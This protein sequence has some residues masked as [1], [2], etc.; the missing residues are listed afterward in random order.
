MTEE[1]KLQKELDELKA[2]LAREK[3]EKAK[4]EKNQSNQNAYITKLE[5]KANGL[6]AQIET[7]KTTANKPALDPQITAYFKKKYVEDFVKEGK[8][9]LKR[10]DT[11]GVFSIM[12]PELDS[13][14]KT[15]MNENN[16]SLKFILDSYSLL[17][18]RA[19]A[20]PEHAINK[21]EGEGVKNTEIQPEPTPTFVKPDFPPTITDA[22]QGAGTPM[23]KKTID[24]PDTKS[25]FKALED[26]LFNQGANKYE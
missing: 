3:E 26:R 14:L 19:I 25:A 10:R 2:E 1:E 13:F 5:E 24:I 18:G 16:A 8:E 23:P 7:I 12:E 9:E 22:D 17:L 4:L 15:Y 21:I 6:S 11:K 20:D